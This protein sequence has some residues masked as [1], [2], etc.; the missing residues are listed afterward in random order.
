MKKNVKDVFLWLRI[1][2]YASPGNF[3][4]CFIT[5]GFIAFFY[6]YL[7]ISTSEII[8]AFTYLNYIQIRNLIILIFILAILSI[9]ALVLQDLN[10]AKL[11]ISLKRA[12]TEAI[13]KKLVNIDILSFEKKEYQNELNYAAQAMNGTQLFSP[14]LA[15]VNILLGTISNIGVVIKT[16][17]DSFGLLL[18]APLILVFA[19]GLKFGAQRNKMYFDSENELMPLV[20]QKNNSQTILVGNHYFKENLIFNFSAHI[21]KRWENKYQEIDKAKMHSVKKMERINL[22]MEIIIT[23][24]FS[25]I[26]FLMLGF[27]DRITAG[28]IV[29]LIGTISSLLNGTKNLSI[30]LSMFFRSVETIIKIESFINKN[31][32]NS[33]HTLE[34]IHAANKECENTISFENVFFNY[35]TSEENIL[36]DVCLKIPLN[37]VTAIVGENGSGKTTLIKLL[38]GIYRPTKGVVTIASDNAYSKFNTY[39]IP[40]NISTVFQG[41]GK[42]YGLSLK[43]NIM[44]GNDSENSIQIINKLEFGDAEKMLGNDFDGSDFSGGQW[45]KIAIYRA[46]IQNNDIIIFDEPTA[47]LDPITEKKIFEQLIELSIGK[48]LIIVTHRMGAAKKADNIVVL[49]NHGIVENGTH[50]ELMEI[51]GKYY[52]MY[53]SQSMWYKENLD[54]D[55][56]QNN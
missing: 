35:P 2:F 42:Y 36:E 12:Y 34:C 10:D 44:L 9:I 47:A 6:Y 31:S 32:S 25:L 45:Q 15:I 41:F 8:D 24:L 52:D 1:G 3:V 27:N 14:T 5:R 30:F 28:S 50:T 48:T 16:T 23:I 17:K 40:T 37:K 43:D 19:I 13:S 49:D 4:L 7:M 56:G 38:C 54:D 22:I 20:R 51:K 39:N 26:L 33:S 53:E 46:I 18:F 29:V 21:K 55:K 11:N